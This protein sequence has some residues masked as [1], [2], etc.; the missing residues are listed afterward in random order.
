MPPAGIRQPGAGSD[1]VGSEGSYATS[2]PHNSDLDRIY[3][4]RLSSGINAGFASY[5]SLGHSVRCAKNSP[6]LKTLTI[7]A[8]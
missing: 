7:H 8:N 2:S 1:N 3:V 5:R 6:N 4:V